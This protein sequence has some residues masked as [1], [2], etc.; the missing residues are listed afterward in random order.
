MIPPLCDLDCQKKKQIQQLKTAYDQDPTNPQKRSAY[1]TAK[2]GQ[3]WVA[4]EKTRVAKEELDSFLTKYSSEYD[5]L[6][7]KISSNNS[8]LDMAKGVLSSEDDI[9]DN[10]QFLN[11]QVGQMKDH[12]NV[13]NRQLDLT[14]STPSYINYII[15]ALYVVLGIVILFLG[16][17]KMDTLKSYFT[18]STQNAVP[19]ML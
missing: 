13:L 4:N 16:V 17:S 19:N 15:D 8:L 6:K 11:T 5:S 9:E 7:N 14:P 3:G 1:F 10:V 2:E 18:S 12:T